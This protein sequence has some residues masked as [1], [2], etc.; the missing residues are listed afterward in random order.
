MHGERRIK[1]VQRV[2][3]SAWLLISENPRYEKE[4]IKPEDMKDVEVLGWC[5]I[6]VGR[7]S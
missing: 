6:R 4:L 2:A 5:E 1:R 7:V 3:G